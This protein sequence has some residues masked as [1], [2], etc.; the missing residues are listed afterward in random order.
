MFAA[1]KQLPVTRLPSYFGAWFGIAVAVGSMIGAGILRAPHDAAA[2]LPNVWTFVGVWILGGTYALLG[3]NAIAELGAMRPRSGGQYAIAYHAFGPFTA[4]A[5]GWADWLSCCGA[6]AAVSIVFAEAAAALLGMPSAVVP[7]S[8][9][10]TL[11][12]GLVLWQGSRTVDASQRLTSAAKFLG[13]MVLTAACLWWGAT[14]ERVVDTPRLVPPPALLTGLVLALQ[15]VIF[16]YDGWVG[17]MYF[18]EEARDPARDILRALFGGVLAVMGV[19][20]LL[21]VALVMVMPLQAIA[22]DPLP[23]ARAATV[24]F[25]ATGETVVRLLVLVALPS[26]ILANLGMGTRV[27]FSLGRDTSK[28]SA[29]GQA[30]ESGAPRGAILLSTAVALAFVSTGTFTRVVAICSVLFV[31]AYSVSFA[32]VFRMRAVEPATPRPWRAIGHPYSTALV[33]LASIA[34]LAGTSM[35]APRDAMIAALL[36][37]LSYPVHRL[38]R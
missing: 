27:L 4:F 25:G 20:V 16:A 3:A 1:V 11:A 31:A 29:L 2:L 17:I 18:G 35:A 28:L 5:V 38:L 15:G 26:G 10:A 8:L 9:A 19:Y 21:N 12:A 23:T 6:V 13:F 24:V 33:F 30:S 34:F 32:A 37:V 7:L 22:S 36:V 14:H